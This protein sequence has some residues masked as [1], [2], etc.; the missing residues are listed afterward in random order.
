MAFVSAKIPKL[1]DTGYTRELPGVADAPGWESEKLSLPN[2]GSR[3]RDK[4][5]DPALL[6]A[7]PR[8]ALGP[9][10]PD[11]GPGPGPAPKAQLP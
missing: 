11:P 3:C 7:P 8:P 6:P 1:R 2:R 5:L 10:S 4:P 9:G